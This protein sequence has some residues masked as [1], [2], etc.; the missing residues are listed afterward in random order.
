MACQSLVGHLAFGRAPD[1]QVTQLSSEFSASFAADHAVDGDASTEWSTDG[2]GDDATA[3]IESYSVTAD[4]TTYGPFPAEIEVYTAGRD[5][6]N[7]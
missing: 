7:S 4:G 2:D 1:V 6:S 5:S 3:I